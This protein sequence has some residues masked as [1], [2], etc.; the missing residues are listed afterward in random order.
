MI[1]STNGAAQSELE[2]SVL[3]RAVWMVQDAGVPMPP[4]PSVYAEAL[5]EVELGQVFATQPA[6]AKLT[7]QAGIARVIAESGWP[8]SG[9]AFGF[10]LFGT[11]G[12]WFYSLVSEQEALLVSVRVSF[13]SERAAES[14]RA[15][16]AHATALLESF[17]SDEINLAEAIASTPAEYRRVVVYSNESGLPR[18]TRATWSAEDGLSEFVPSA[19]IF[20][21][22]G[23]AP[24]QDGDGL[25][26]RA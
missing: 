25:L 22:R 10:T 12:C 20:S 3:Q 9:L 19:D 16:I 17:L 21:G 18:E 11:G 26:I 2:E 23:R 6:L 4:I 14:G 15:S 13:Y 24:S 1:D 5:S 8:S 7:T